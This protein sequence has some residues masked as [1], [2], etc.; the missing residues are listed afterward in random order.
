M[1][2]I[3]E[4]RKEFSQNSSLGNQ[5]YHAEEVEERFSKYKPGKVRSAVFLFYSCSEQ[6]SPDRDTVIFHLKKFLNQSD[7]KTKMK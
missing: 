7:F 3:N 5:R 6:Q 1:A 2:R 4:K